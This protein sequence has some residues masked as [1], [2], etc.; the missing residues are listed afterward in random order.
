MNEEP[1]IN[2]IPAKEL[3]STRPVPF[4]ESLSDFGLLK[5]GWDQF[6]DPLPDY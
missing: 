6:M 1:K 5:I 2:F 3:N 4:I